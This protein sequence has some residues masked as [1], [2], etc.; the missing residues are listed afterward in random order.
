MR[1]D[2]SDS[3]EEVLLQ[4]SSGS[5]N[6]CCHESSRAC[7]AAFLGSAN[8]VRQLPGDWEGS[9]CYLASASTR[10][11]NSGTL[12]DGTNSTRWS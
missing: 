7:A 11:E 2:V 10:W 9:F 12:A 1:F 5:E 3:G 6:T 4:V 8:L